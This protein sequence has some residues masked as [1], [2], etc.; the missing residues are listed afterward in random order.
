[1]LCTHLP[2][3]VRFATKTCAIYYKKKSGFYDRQKKSIAATFN[4]FSMPDITNGSNRQLSTSSFPKIAAFAKNR[5]QHDNRR[6][7]AVIT[8]KQTVNNVRNYKREALTQEAAGVDNT[9]ARVKIGEWQERIKDFT[10]QTHLERDRAHEFIGTIDGKQPRGIAPSKTAADTKETILN[11]PI[12]KEYHFI[13]GKPQTITAQYDREIET[14]IEKATTL[15][16]TQKIGNI[17]IDRAE[18][19]GSSIYEEI[20]KVREMG[21]KDIGLRMAKGSDA[22]AMKTIGES[23]SYLP[24]TAGEKIIDFFEKHNTKALWDWRGSLTG[25]SVICLDGD[26]TTG[27]HE[28]AHV[29][30]KINP[31]LA[32][33]EKEF[34]NKRT[35]GEELKQL[36]AVT[37]KSGYKNTELC[38]VDNFLNPYIGKYINGKEWEIFTTGLEHI[39]FNRYRGTDK[40]F[41][42]FII[43]LLLRL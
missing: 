7:K 5:A 15:K 42:S 11:A 8:V 9:A 18:K 28:L 17:I 29:L 43:G 25:T 40:D 4:A 41:E 2:S 19:N 14:M 31:W 37:G 6:K 16:D 10:Q 27:V 13:T 12:E 1:M 26:I 30:E 34:Y 20:A 32:E 3:F 36:S 21:V 24:K 35:A 38:K 22:G 23:L 39:Y 33:L